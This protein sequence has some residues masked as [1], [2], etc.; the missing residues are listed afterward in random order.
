MLQERKLLEDRISDF[1]SNMAEEEEKVKSLS[2]L[3]NKYEA[4]IAD[5]EGRKAILLYV[6]SLKA[7]W[8]HTR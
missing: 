2:K 1:T 7:R 6:H 4:V 8:I 3:R 5:M